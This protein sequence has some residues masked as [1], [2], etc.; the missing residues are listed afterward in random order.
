MVAGAFDDL[1]TDRT[2][3]ISLFRLVLG[4]QINKLPG[5][6]WTNSIAVMEDVRKHIPATSNARQPPTGRAAFVVKHGAKS[7]RF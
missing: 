4:D 2:R 7:R 3:D 6:L 5:I 1:L